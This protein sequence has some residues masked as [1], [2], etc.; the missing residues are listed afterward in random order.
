[1]EKMDTVPEKYWDSQTKVVG[2]RSMGTGTGIDE[3]CNLEILT[4]GQ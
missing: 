4:L 1:M 3:H 2:K